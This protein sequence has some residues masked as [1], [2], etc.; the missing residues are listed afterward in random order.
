M[1]MMMSNDAAAL[2]VTI[3]VDLTSEH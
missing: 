1:M 3:E 2:E